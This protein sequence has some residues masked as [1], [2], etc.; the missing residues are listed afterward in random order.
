[1]KIIDSNKNIN[2]LILAPHTDD[3]EFGCGGLIARMITLGHNVHYVAFSSCDESLPEGV[4]AG[5]L[6]EELGE[7]AQILGIPT[8]N[9]KVLDY[10]VRNFAAHRQNIL[11]DMV[12]MNKSLCPDMVFLPSTS[13]TH[14]DHYTISVEG[15]RAFKNRTIIGYE[16]PWNNLRFTSNF[17]FK[18]TENEIQLKIQAIQA[19]KSQAAKIYSTPKFIESLAIMR[20]GQVNAEY[21]EC[22]ELIRL[23]AE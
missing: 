13:D 9:I 17:Y 15:F 5:T 3:G 20:G 16:L 7:A 14:Q 19:Y 4:P 18:L 23:I 21:A 6:V 11:E 10:P 1:M 8:K 2:I 12:V 22:F